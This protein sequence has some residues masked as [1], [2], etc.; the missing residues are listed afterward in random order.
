MHKFFYP[1]SVAVVGA[2]R[3]PDSVGHAIMRNLINGHFAGVLYPV[4]PK[5]RAVLGVKAY[6]KISAIPDTIDLAI[7]VVPNKIVPE[8]MEECVEVGVQAAVIITAGFKEIGPE[9][10][11]LEQ[12]VVAIARRGGIRFIG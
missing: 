3:D 11:K 8:V 2:S 9:G 1:S 7:I 4:N 12:E 10:A 6:P 5:A